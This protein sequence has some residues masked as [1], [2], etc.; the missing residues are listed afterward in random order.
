M[1]VQRLMYKKCKED[2]GDYIPIETCC[3]EHND[4][5]DQPPKTRLNCVI[6]VINMT[7]MCGPMTNEQR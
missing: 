1:I 7:Q 6:S 2:D 4:I 3:S 5:N